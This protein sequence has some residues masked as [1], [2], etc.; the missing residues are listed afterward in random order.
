MGKKKTN[1]IGSSLE[2]FLKE[3]GIYEKVQI[4]ALKE[5]LVIQIKE[6]MRKANISQTELAK[7]MGTSRAVLQRLLDVHNFSL[8]LNTLFNVSHALGKE[9]HIHLTDPEKSECTYK[10]ENL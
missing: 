1:C 10:K 8:T 4:E 7:K 2:S 5:T 6:A 9:L 3:E